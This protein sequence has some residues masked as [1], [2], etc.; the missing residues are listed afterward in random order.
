MVCKRMSPAVE[1]DALWRRIFLQLPEN[2]R[3]EPSTKSDSDGVGVT[4]LPIEGHFKTRFL[5]IVASRITFR[6]MRAARKIARERRRLGVIHGLRRAVEVLDPT[7]KTSLNGKEVGLV[8]SI[9]TRLGGWASRANIL[10]EPSSR[11][12]MR[13]FSLSSSIKIDVPLSVTLR[14]VHS[15]RTLLARHELDWLSAPLLKVDNPRLSQRH[16]VLG[17][18][19]DGFLTLLEIPCSRSFEAIGGRRRGPPEPRGTIVAGVLGDAGVGG[20]DVDA[21]V[22]LMTLH[23]PHQLILNSSTRTMKNRLRRSQNYGH[24]SAGALYGLEN[25]GAAIGL[26]TT[27]VPLWETCSLGVVTGYIS[28]RDTRV[29]DT[30]SSGSLPPTSSKVIRLDLVSPG[31][32]GLGGAQ[33]EARSLSGPPNMPFTTTGGLSGVV[34]DVLLAE[35]ALFDCHGD[36]LWSFTSSIVFATPWIRN[37]VGGTEQL[38]LDI[39]HSEVVEERRQGL[40]EEDGVGRVIIELAQVDSSEKEGTVSTLLS[41]SPT[42]HEWIVRSA[43]VELELEFI[44]GWFGTQHGRMK[45]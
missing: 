17:K 43:W 12:G 21:V 15:V 19:R 24:D 13:I 23:M 26:R 1:N 22:C 6:S 33:G 16:R 37:W 44:D 27:A 30:L 31:A 3:R 9:G 10:T 35:F 14:Q 8:D 7:L 25:L 4:L 39:S 32:G 42:A 11:R 2:L 45:M 40:V 20:E 29:R 38:V 18:S 41:R 28:W 36:P 34:E 5:T